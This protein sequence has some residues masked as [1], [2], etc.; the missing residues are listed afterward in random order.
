MYF[1]PTIKTF[2]NIGRFR[3]RFF[4]SRLFLGIRLEEL[5]DH[6]QKFLVL[7]NVDYI[8]DSLGDQRYL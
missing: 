5:T 2:A 4:D 3:L 7:Q 6:V 1:G 8:D